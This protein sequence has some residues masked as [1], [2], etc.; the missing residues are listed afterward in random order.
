MSEAKDPRS[1]AADEVQFRT[2]VL[3]KLAEIGRDVTHV[4]GTCDETKQ[5]LAEHIVHDNER[6]GS[7]D[8]RLGDN[9]SSIAKGWGIVAAIVVM[10]GV[11]FSI[12]Q[13]VKP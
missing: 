8:Q 11:I 3:V 10:I 6:F 2:S 13:L 7:V 5:A 4:K 9:S 1:I 12:I